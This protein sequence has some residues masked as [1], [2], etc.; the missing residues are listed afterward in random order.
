MGLQS[1]IAPR[2]LCRSRVVQHTAP[3]G[4]TRAHGDNPRDK[5]GRS[6]VSRHFS[7]SDPSNHHLGFHGVPQS[8]VSV[9]PS[10]PHK[11][12]TGNP[13]V[14]PFQ[15]LSVSVSPELP[16]ASP[17]PQ[18]TNLT[19]L[20]LRPYSLR[21]FFVSMSHGKRICTSPLGIE[22]DQTAVCCLSQ[23]PPLYASSRDPTAVT[24]GPTAGPH[25][26]YPG[27]VFS[28]CLVYA[29]TSRNATAYGAAME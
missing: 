16:P 2:V 10:L 26:P 22:D 7:P 3:H 28:F 1:S 11:P 12:T 17:G 15:V 13:H 27:G 6:S 24:L 9:P 25:S 19:H 5:C 23:R 21:A 29:G 14:R 8:T 20:L 4:T 18:L